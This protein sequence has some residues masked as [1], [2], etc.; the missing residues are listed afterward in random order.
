MARRRT[1]LG[2]LAAGALFLA[3]AALFLFTAVSG[4]EVL[5]FAYQ[6]V[7]FVAAFALV[8]LLRRRSHRSTRTGAG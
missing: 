7:A 5:P 3:V 1:D 8:L 6:A 4:T 2:S